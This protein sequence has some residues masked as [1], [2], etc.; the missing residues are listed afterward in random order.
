MADHAGGLI[1]EGG[2]HGSAHRKVA[3]VAG[4]SRRKVIGQ[5]RQIHFVAD[6]AKEYGFTDVDGRQIP[7]FNPFGKR[8]R[9]YGVAP[10]R[11]GITNVRLAKS[12]HNVSGVYSRS[13]ADGFH[14]KRS[15]FAAANAA[16]S[17]A[18]DRCCRS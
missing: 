18:G 10:A 1:G 16:Q 15:G 7:H 4:A 14:D 9:L 8:V 13:S 3:V 2:S 12:D 11:S 5:E 6:L 17:V